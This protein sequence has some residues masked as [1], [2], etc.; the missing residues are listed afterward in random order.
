[1]YKR[2]SPFR[3]VVKIVFRPG[4]GYPFFGVPLAE[5]AD[6]AVPLH[7]LWGAEADILLEKLVDAE[8]DTQR[9]AEMKDA[10]IARLQGPKIF[11]PVGVQLVTESLA[12]LATPQATLQKVA[13]NLDVS[14][15]NLRRAFSAVVGLSPKRYARIARFQ[16]AVARASLGE[17]C[18]AEIAA[19]SGYFDQA[20]MC[21]DFREIAQLSPAAFVRPT[22]QALVVQSA[23]PECRLSGV[24]HNPKDR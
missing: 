10:L 20:H 13:G 16:R 1:M 9:L 11:E 17:H 22:G 5:L 4:G 8:A 18:W 3:A 7:D 14:E 12:Q 23:L 24:P 21:L 15:R 6:R 19:E 2:A